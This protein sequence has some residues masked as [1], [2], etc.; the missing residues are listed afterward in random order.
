VGTV[1]RRCTPDANAIPWL[2]LS[3]TPGGEPGI[4]RRTTYIQRVSTV[5][6]LAPASAGLVV[7]EVREVPYTA[8]YRFFRAD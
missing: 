7:G 3:A 1:M 2:L 4:F 8:V 5:G 6:G